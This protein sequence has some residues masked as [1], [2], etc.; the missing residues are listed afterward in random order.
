MFGAVG[1]NVTATP[2]GAPVPYAE[3]AVSSYAA[4][5]A[6]C[7]LALKGSCE[8]VS[9]GEDIVQNFLCAVNFQR[10]VLQHTPTL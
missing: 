1:T 7:E 10:Q 3:D 9:E 4:P 8:W 6:N 2:G 5:V